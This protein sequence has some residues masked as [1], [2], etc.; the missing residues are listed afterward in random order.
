VN[1][2]TKTTEPV[3]IRQNKSQG[4]EPDFAMLMDRPVRRDN[5]LQLLFDDTRYAQAWRV[6][7]L[8]A[9]CRTNVP[10][11]LHGSPADCMAVV[12]QAHRWNMDPF[13]VAQKTYLVKGGGML[14]YESQLVNAVVAN[15]GAVTG[16]FRYEWDGTGEAMICRA[17]AV[18]RGDSEITWTNWMAK[19]QFSPQ[20]SP[21]WKTNPAQQMAYAQCRNWAR[22]YAPGAILGVYAVDEFD[23]G[24]GNPAGYTSSAT[25]QEAGMASRGNG[26]MSGNPG[27]QA[28]CGQPREL[29]AG[30]YPDDRFMSKAVDFLNKI[31]DG[32]PAGDV[33]AFLERKHVLSAWQKAVLRGERSLEEYLVACE[34]GKSGDA[35]AETTY[36]G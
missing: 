19:C 9:E 35:I 17:G 31:K 34:E 30:N 6:A 25:A 27:Q 13:A 7:C 16:P 11:F 22:L 18:L 1:T 8:M 4:L 20:N 10:A 14:A 29:A 36:C 5:A 3:G 21:L 15:S 12:L 28:E 23:N 32:K 2:E 24:G 33:I 26:F